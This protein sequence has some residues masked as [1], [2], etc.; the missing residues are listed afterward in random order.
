MLTFGNINQYSPVV[1]DELQ[2]ET[3]NID[4]WLEFCG[5]GGIENCEALIPFYE[6][7]NQFRQGGIVS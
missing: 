3:S 1:P 6:A 7:A 4:Y 5:N 2:T